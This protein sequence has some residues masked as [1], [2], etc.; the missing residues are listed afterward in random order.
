MPDST[1]TTRKQTIEV[2]QVQAVDVTEIVDDQSGGKVR[3]VRVY[4]TPDG[5]DAPPVLTVRV[6]A[7]TADPLQ[8]TTPQLDY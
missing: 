2:D 7:D 8:L 6:K 1:L 4:G 3:E 5:T